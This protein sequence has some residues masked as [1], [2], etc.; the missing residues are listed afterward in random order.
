MHTQVDINKD[1]ISCRIRVNGKYYAANLVW[2]AADQINAVKISKQELIFQLESDLLCKFSP[3]RGVV[4]FG[5]AD[6][7][8]VS[9]HNLPALAANI[10]HPNNSSFC[11]VWQTEENIWI[12]IGKH[13]QEGIIA[14]HAFSNKEDAIREFNT[15]LVQ[16]DWDSI[17]V[18]DDSWGVLP[19]GDYYDLEQL[20][21]KK[22]RCRIK[23]SK[24]QKIQNAIKIIV[25]MAILAGGY[26]GYSYWHNLQLEKEEQQRKLRMAEMERNKPKIVIAAAPWLSQPDKMDFLQQ[27]IDE[28]SKYKIATTMMPGWEASGTSECSTTQVTY[29]IKRGSAT[30]NWFD[31]MKDGIWPK[32]VIDVESE[33]SVKLS[34]P[35]KINIKNQSTY[36]YGYDEVKKYLGEQ[37]S[38]LNMADIKFSDPVNDTKNIGWEKRDFNIVI[39]KDPKVYL[40]I[41]EKITNMV[42]TKLTYSGQKEGWTVYGTLYSKSSQ[43]TPK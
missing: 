21:S 20:I 32:P 29:W 12:V 7:N 38:E 33:N 37:L 24:K 5:I 19:S 22:I 11:G 16:C 28:M 13:Q 26:S 25:A 31:F 27:C 34:W 30:K 9:A 43:L 3:S 6:A 23:S 36:Q 10:V 2:T 17:L 41:V 8:T 42:F 35:I 40:P 39:D 1:D 14:D 15:T 18:P 4:Q